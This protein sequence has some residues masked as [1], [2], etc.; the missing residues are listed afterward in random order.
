MITIG[1][2]ES[3]NFW[4]RHALSLQLLRRAQH[5]GGTAARWEG[6]WLPLHCCA[7]H[8]DPHMTAMQCICMLCRTISWPVMLLISQFV[9][10][11]R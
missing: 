8:N 2:G 4:V 7:V 5:M 3:T 1:W 10:E 9:R 11:I 6:A